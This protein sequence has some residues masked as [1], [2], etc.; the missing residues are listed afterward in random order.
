MAAPPPAQKSLSN[1]LR[2]HVPRVVEILRKGEFTIDE[3]RQQL[4]NRTSFASTRSILH[5]L[6]AEGEV[7][8][9]ACEGRVVFFLTDKRSVTEMTAELAR[10]WDIPGLRLEQKNTVLLL[11]C[12]EETRRTVVLP[13]G[14]KPEAITTSMILPFVQRIAALAKEELRQEESKPVQISAEDRRDDSQLHEELKNQARKRAMQR[15]LR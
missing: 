14:W 2:T 1:V 15:R 8:S 5:N 10:T 12:G 13:L 4:G 9:R 7:S 6:H 11:R 3:V